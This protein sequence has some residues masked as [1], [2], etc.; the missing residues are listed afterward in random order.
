MRY[1]Y[2]SARSGFT[3]YGL[4]AVLPIAEFASIVEVMVKAICEG[5]GEVYDTGLTRTWC[6]TRYLRS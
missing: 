3:W 2:L 5:I 4:T 6:L 1:E